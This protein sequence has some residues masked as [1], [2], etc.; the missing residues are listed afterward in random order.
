MTN[1]AASTDAEIVA[2]LLDN[3]EESDDE[4]DVVEVDEPLAPL[5]VYEI[6]STIETLSK[7]S[8]FCEGDDVKFQV[9]SLAKEINTPLM[10]RKKAENN[11]L[12]LYLDRY[13]KG[14]NFW[15]HEY[16]INIF[17]TGCRML[18]CDHT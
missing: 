4:S 17:V 14:I 9:D 2:E 8:L 7:F 10:G 13:F 3:G 1:G 15:W 12:L 18:S 16:L 6:E 5:S 11:C